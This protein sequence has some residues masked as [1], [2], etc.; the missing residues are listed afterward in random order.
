MATVMPAIARNPDAPSAHGVLG[1]MAGGSIGA[2]TALV[3]ISRQVRSNQGRT[4]MNSNLKEPLR[5]YSQ[6]TTAA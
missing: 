4:C 2:R 6:H 3:P 5:D 1:T